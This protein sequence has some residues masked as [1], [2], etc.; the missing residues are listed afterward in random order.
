MLQEAES[1][2]NHGFLWKVRYWVMEKICIVTRKRRSSE[3]A[4]S[5]I[6]LIVM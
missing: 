5:P 1:G 3:V 2:G 6:D 4:Q